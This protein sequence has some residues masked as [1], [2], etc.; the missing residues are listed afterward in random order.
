MNRP[1]SPCIAI[2]D[3]LYKDVCSGCGR[4]YLEVANWVSMSEAEKEAVWVRIEQEGTAKR[5][6]TYKDRVNG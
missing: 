5:F 2:C 4:H 1:D 6:N 3:T